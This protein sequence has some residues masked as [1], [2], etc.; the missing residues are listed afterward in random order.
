[1]KMCN[2]KIKMNVLYSMALQVFDFKQ[3]HFFDDFD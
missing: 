3:M 1:M 2:D